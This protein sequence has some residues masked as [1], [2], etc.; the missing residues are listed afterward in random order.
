MKQFKDI[1]GLVMLLNVK[2]SNSPRCE[3]WEIGSYS[4]TETECGMLD[5]KLANMTIGILV[6]PLNAIKT[7]GYNT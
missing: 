2:S 3:I 1:K 4:L 7:N 6:T 5:R